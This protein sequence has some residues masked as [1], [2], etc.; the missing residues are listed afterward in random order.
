MWTTSESSARA[1]ESFDRYGIVRSLDEVQVRF[2]NSALALHLLMV[3]SRRRLIELD[4]HVNRS[5][6][7]A[8][9]ESL[10]VSGQLV[11]FAAG[12]GQSSDK[13]HDQCQ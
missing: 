1:S 5:A 10:K 9:F 3:G 13:Q 2:Q 11:L 12:K 7:M 8:A 4:D 6:V